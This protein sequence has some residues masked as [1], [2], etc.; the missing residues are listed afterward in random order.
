MTTRPHLGRI[1]RG[2]LSPNTQVMVVPAEGDACKGRVLQ[3]MGYLWLE[4]VD[5]ES[6]DFIQQWVF[7]EFEET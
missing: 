4:R 1:T 3:V 2:K 6:A 7:G 5:V